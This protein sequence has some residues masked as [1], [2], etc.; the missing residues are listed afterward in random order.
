VLQPIPLKENLVPRLK[1]MHKS[2]WGCGGYL[3]G[4]NSG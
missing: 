3:D 1:R 4:R 2:E